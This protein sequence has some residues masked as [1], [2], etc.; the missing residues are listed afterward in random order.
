MNDV[1]H[2]KCARRIWGILKKSVELRTRHQTRRVDFRGSQR[3]DE[4]ARYGCRT[5]WAGDRWKSQ[6]RKNVYLSPYVEE[7]LNSKVI[8]K[9]R[10]WIK[11]SLRVFRVSGFLCSMYICYKHYMYVLHIAISWLCNISTEHNSL[12]TFT[13]AIFYERGYRQNSRKIH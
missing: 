5:R 2:R 4:F 13:N 10:T 3:P 12:K 1:I 7:P 9:F 6:N 8:K 11:K